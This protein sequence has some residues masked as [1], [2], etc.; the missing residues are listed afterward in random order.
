MRSL[1][2]AL[3]KYDWCPYKRRWAHWQAQ[4]GRPCADTGQDS[5]LEAKKGPQKKCTLLTLWSQISGYQDCE[6][7]PLYCLSTPCPP[8][9][10]AMVRYYGNP[11]EIVQIYIHNWKTPALKILRTHICTYLSG[12]VSKEI[13]SG[14]G[15]RWAC[16]AQWSGEK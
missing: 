7:V 14:S 10:P 9:R 8:P 4:R 5:H 11:C 12:H 1:G 16:Y 2:R 3:I 15:S 13:F 6:D